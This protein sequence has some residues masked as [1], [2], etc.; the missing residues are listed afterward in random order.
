M[1][2]HLDLFEEG[3][4][5]DTARIIVAN[6][7]SGRLLVLGFRQGPQN[8]QTIATDADRVLTIE[9]LTRFAR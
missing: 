9:L 8:S 6:H 5:A 1:F 7:I 3:S 4:S 2:L